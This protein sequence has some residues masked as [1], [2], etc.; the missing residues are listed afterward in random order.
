[1]VNGLDMSRDEI[2]TSGGIAGRPV[3]LLV[4]DTQ[5]KPDVA[6]NA[7]L[8]LTG[9]D[10]VAALIGAYLSEETNA[11]LQVATQ[12][13][14]LLIVPVSADDALTQNVARDYG[15][16]RYLFRVSYDIDQ[17]AALMGDFVAG[18]LKAR[19]Y[20]FV[21]TGIDWN[22]ALAAALR[23]YLAPKGVQKVYETYYSPLQPAYD[24]VLLALKQARPQVVV[25]ADP[26][27]G[28]VGLVKAARVQGLSMPVFSVG[29]ALGS[30]A[31]AK[32]LG[33]PGPVYFQAAA[34]QG[35]PPANAFFATYAREF[36]SAPA[37]YSDVLAHDALSVLAQAM[38]KAGSTSPGAV[39]PV[40]EK[41]EFSGV[42]GTYRFDA[43][44]QARWGAGEGLGGVVV[45]WVAGQGVVGRP[46]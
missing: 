9:E 23:N 12:S 46:K 42:A 25:L 44:H 33:Y 8:K 4:E 16:Y 24:P 38:N 18:G 32:T 27:G 17:W 40:L 36:G 5:G 11:V 41:G 31:V 15:Q 22:H 35:T 26:G 45:Q 3:R 37:G 39:I 19:S 2:N 10:H 7:A 13:K 21:G 43:S 29:G 34:W 28:S 6:R 20:A 1:M 30:Q 14:T